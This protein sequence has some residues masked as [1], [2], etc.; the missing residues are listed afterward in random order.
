MKIG[1]NIK[2]IRISQKMEQKDLAEKL[3]LSNKTISSWECD[4]T[5]PNIGMLEDIAEALNVTTAELIETDADGLT[6]EEM[7]LLK[8][9][10]LGQYKT[11]IYKIMEKI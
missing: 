4:R 2:A 8:L 6:D 1:K 10:R 7:E 11:L 9:Y 5:E 3:H